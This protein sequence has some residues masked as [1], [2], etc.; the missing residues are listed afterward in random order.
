M[1]PRA[2]RA[3]ASGDD[4]EACHNCE[5]APSKVPGSDEGIFISQQ[6]SGLLPITLTQNN[7]DD[8]EA[9]GRIYSRVLQVAFESLI[10]IYLIYASLKR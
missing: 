2:L 6:G 5:H 3:S 7:Y 9:R 4:N 1:A 10:S 8:E